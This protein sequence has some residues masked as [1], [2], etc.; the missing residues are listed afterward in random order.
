MSEGADEPAIDP[1]RP[2]ID[3]HLHHWDI[4]PGGAIEEQRFLFPE[5]LDLLNGC[6]HRITHTVFVQCNSMYRAKG[7]EELKPLGETEFVTGISAM[8]ASGHYGSLRLAHRIVGA[9]DLRLGAAVRPVIERHVEIAGERFRG[10]RTDTMYNPAGMF[11]FPGDHRLRGIM[12]DP[13]FREGA[14]VLAEM[15]L[16]L[17]VWCAHSQLAD[18]SDLA[19][20]VPGLT[21]VLDHVGTP[22]DR[23]ADT[24]RDRLGGIREL[25]RRDNVRIKLGGL[26][27]RLDRPPGALVGRASS[28]DLAAAW[29]PYIDPCIEAFGAYRA[30][31]ESNFPPDQA[32]GSYGATWNAFKRIAAGYSEAEQDRLFRGTAA[33]VYRIA[34]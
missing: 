5:T 15:D 13:G 25:S 29:A 33:D 3:P 16:S 17:D 14:R 12:G 6:G 31:F 18:L 1:D 9:A 21:I 34:I 32:A 19:D 27:M 11:G 23:S 30:M 8:S 24:R 28:A 4:L 26:G 2:I 10:I 22:T 20:F 7:P